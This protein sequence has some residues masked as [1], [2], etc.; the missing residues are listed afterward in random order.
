MKLWPCDDGT[1]G[2]CEVV[3]RRRGSVAKFWRVRLWAGTLFFLSC[4]G[5]E[6]PRW[7]QLSCRAQLTFADRVHDLNAGDGDRRRPE[8][9]EAQCRTAVIDANL[10]HSK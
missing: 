8:P 3:G 9:L 4:E 1:T 5:V 10:S 2:S 6:L 7:A